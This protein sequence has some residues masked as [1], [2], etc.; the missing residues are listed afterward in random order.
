[1]DLGCR[2]GRTLLRRVNADSRL[3]IVIVLVILAFTTRIVP[4]TISNLPFNNDGISECRIASDILASGHL[5]Y[6]DGSFYIASH[7]AVTPAYDILLAST[8]SAIG[9]TPLEVAQ[10]V[11]AVFSVITVVGIYLI[12][13]QITK[14]RPAS[15]TAAFT[16][17]LLG[18]FVYLTGSTWKESLGVALL[19]V[20][21]YAYMNRSR[22]EMFALEL[23]IL[24]IF[25]IVHHYIT[26]LVYLILA[27]LTLWS[28]VRAAMVRKLLRRHL[29]DSAVLGVV[30]VAAYMYYRAES[31]DRLAYIS[32]EGGFVLFAL[33]FA[34]VSGAVLVLLAR[35]S[36]SRYTFAYVPA[37][38][39]L[40]LFVYDYYFPVFPYS[41][42]SPEYVLMLGI[43][44]SIIIGFAWFGFESILETKSVYRSIP[45]GMLAPAL[46]LI[47]FAFM[48]GLD[49]AG[50]QIVYR[51]FDFADPALAVGI[52]C[53]VACNL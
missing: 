6:P 41:Q 40:G 48:S 42:G 17:S 8:A 44:S 51:T 16:L 24:A 5:D 15:L 20:V 31:L 33:S 1:M 50:H 53:A 26:L 45:L 13:F 32:G 35:R 22:K 37:S 11:V 9:V 34:V 7:T 43:T 25:P 27:T 36:H 2:W 19:I 49:R 30:G 14:S 46:T 18:T 29:L 4:L 23:T 47:L 39:I 12:S 28:V 21:T 10:A 38:F 52:A 3:A